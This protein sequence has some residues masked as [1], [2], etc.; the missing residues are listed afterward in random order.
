MQTTVDALKVLGTKCYRSLDTSHAGLLPQI[1][2]DPTYLNLVNFFG[3]LTNDTGKIFYAGI[4]ELADNII[5]QLT[6]L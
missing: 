6:Q 5:C 2:Q 1:W 4:D 3:H